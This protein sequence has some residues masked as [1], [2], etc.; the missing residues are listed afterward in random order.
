[1]YFFIA[2]RGRGRSNQ[3][4]PRAPGGSNKG[5]WQNQGVPN[6]GRGRGGGI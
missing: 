5:P 1:M 2:A 6:T 3:P 4:G